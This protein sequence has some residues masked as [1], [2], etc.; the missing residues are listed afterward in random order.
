MFFKRLLLPPKLLWIGIGIFFLCIIP[1]RLNAQL[2]ADFTVDNQTG[3]LAVVSSFTDLS[4]GNPNSWSWTFFYNGVAVD[5]RLTQNPGKI[6]TQ[7]GC[8][9]VQLVV[10]DAAGNRDTLRRNCY[11]EVFENPGMDFQVD[12][13]RAC[14]P[15]TFSFTN[16]TVANADSLQSCTWVFINQSTLSSVSSNANDPV[17]SLPDTGVYDVQL[18]CTNSNGCVNTIRRNGFLR[19]LPT[20][21][22]N[23]TVSDT[24]ACFLPHA[25]TLN[26]ASQDNGAGGLSYAWSIPGG[27]PATATGLTPPPISFNSTNPF[28]AQ[29][30][31]TSAQGCSDSVS[32]TAAVV[33]RSFNGGVTISDTTPCV[34][35][36]VSFQD[37]TPGILSRRWQFGDGTPLLTGP[38]PLVSHTYTSTGTY[39]FSLISTNGFGCE[40]TMVRRIRVLPR[41]GVN[42][43]V[44]PALSCDI[45]TSFAFSD[46][47][48]GGATSWSWDFGDGNTSTLQNPSHT[49]GSAGFYTV[50]LTVTDTSGCDSTFCI[51]SAVSLVTPQAQFIASTD[52]GCA[53]YVSQLTDNSI[54]ND[55]IISWS[56]TFDDGSGTNVTPGT[57][58]LENPNVT[59]LNP[60]TYNVTLVIQTNSGCSDSVTVVNYLRAGPVP[61]VDFTADKDT[62]CI[63]ETVNF[64]SSFTNPAYNYFWDF[65]YPSTASQGNPTMPW[66]YTDT[67]CFDVSLEIEINGCRDSIVKRSM[68]CVDPPLADFT[69]NPSLICLTPTNVV[70][71]NLSQGQVTQHNWYFNNALISTSPNPPPIPVPPSFPSG[72]YDLKLVV[73]NSLTGCTDSLT[74]SVIVGNVTADFSL[75]DKTLCVGDTL[76]VF[77]NS[78]NSTARTLLF[79]DGNLVAGP[80]QPVNTHV[81][82]DTGFFTVR[83]IVQDNRSGCRDTLDKVDSIR[84]DAAFANFSGVGLE[85]C[86]GLVSQFSDSSFASRGS[87]IISWLWDFGDTTNNTATTPNASNAYNGRGFYTVSLAVEAANGCRD[88][89]A[90]RNFVDISQPLLDFTPDPDTTCPGNPVTFLNQ[91]QGL[92]VQYQWIFGTAPGDTST[93]Q[94]PIR[95]YTSLGSKGVILSG[96][97]R[98][99]CT[100]TLVRPHAVFVEDITANFIADRTTGTCPPFSVQFTDLSTGRVDSV[101]WDFGDG[102]RSTQRDPQHI[103]SAPGCFDVTLI[104]FHRDGCSDTL[105]RPCYIDIAGPTA[106]LFFSPSMACLGDTVNFGVAID[107]AA[108]VFLDL[109]DGLVSTTFPQNRTDTVFFQHVYSDTGYFNPVV[110]VQ[111]ARLC[112]RTIPADSSIRILQLPQPQMTPSAFSGCAPFSVNLIDNSAP[113]D[114]NLLGWTWGIST[115]DT[116]VARDTAYTFQNVGI[117][118]VT[119]RVEDAFGCVNDI[120][121]AFEAQSSPV[122]DFVA[123]DSFTCAP[124]SIDF[125]DL[126]SNTLVVDWIWSFG[127]GDSARGVQNP[128]LTYP[129][130]GSYDVSLIVFD[131]NNCSDTLTKS[132]YIRLRHPE[133]YWYADQLSACAPDDITFYADSAQVR[134]DT[135]LQRYTWQLSLPGGQTGTATGLVGSSTDSLNQLYTAPGSYGVTLIVE[136]VFGC[137][138]TLTDSVQL[139]VPPVADFGIADPTGCAPHTTQ[140]WDQSQVGDAPLQG[141]VYD[142]STGDTAFTDSPFYAFQN[143]GVYTVRQL[144]VDANGCVDTSSQQVEIFDSPLP[145]FAASD[146]FNCSPIDIS[147]TDLSSNTT[148]AD[149]R[150]DFGDGNQLSGVQNPTHRYTADGLFDVKLVVTDDQGCVDSLIKSQYIHLRRPTAYIYSNDPS[151]CNPVTLTFFADSSRLLSDTTLTAYTWMIET[152]QGLQAPVTTTVDTFDQVYPVFGLY[153]VVLVVEDVFG[154]TDTMRREDYVEIEETTVPNPISLDVVS[155]LG[156][157]EIE[158]EWEQ[159]PGPARNFNQYYVLRQNPTGGAYLPVDSLPN[160]NTT[161]YVD[162]DPDLDTELRPYRYKIQVQNSC[163]Q[164]SD[165]DQTVAHRTVWLR[166]S[167]EIDAIRLDWS[168]YEGWDP[169]LYQVYGARD[170]NP[171]SLSLIATVPGDRFTFTDTATFCSDVKSYR[172]IAVEGQ[173]ANLRSLSNLDSVAPIHLPPEQPVNISY[174]SVRAD[175]VIDLAWE[176]Y[177]GY[178]PQSYHLEKSSDGTSWALLDTFDL[179]TLQTTDPDVKVDEE[180]YAYRIRAFDQCG[181][182]SPRGYLGVSILLQVELNGKFPELSWTHYREWPLGVLAYEIEVLNESTGLWETVSGVSGNRTRFIDDLTDLNQGL[183][184]YRIRALEARGGENEATSNVACIAFNPRVFAPNAFSPNGDDINDRFIVQGATLRQGQISIFNRWGQMIYSSGDLSEGWDG[185]YEGVAVPEGVYVYV[186]EGQGENGLPISLRGS[187][188]LIR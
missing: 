52:R 113:G 4:N 3:C 35:S 24:I 169:A 109:D 130:D 165:L 7:P 8:H 58:T 53:P 183:Y 180:T 39:T 139:F 102:T 157:R 69:V 60:G 63:G 101:L 20:P 99:G 32:R 156:K 89:L 62:V 182:F 114:T 85:G 15:G 74:Q 187:I 45:N 47:S 41:P 33:L 170:Y 163:L 138:D 116:L 28:T 105:F 12:T 66:A 136:D 40:D 152:D 115:G 90:R 188:T 93:L 166:A 71:T 179:N 9:D 29:L 26:D 86:P 108:S 54:T 80:A 143:P 30:K 37:N 181:D 77:D 123:S 119:L 51:P 61:N 59:V 133:A 34:N 167:P 2:T 147:F 117:Y 176:P 127:N 13:N 65:S 153:D 67:G 88:T 173:G 92:A 50:C 178:L 95:T 161:R 121:Q 122:A 140:F 43:S 134:S 104:A 76:R 23:F 159:F 177:T 96:I 18:R 118:N 120:T 36:P 72:V 70:I 151:G 164:N 154:C 107:S 46:L 106:E 48:T 97:D 100:D 131:G 11:I 149:W 142:F 162:S 57:S 145:D 175:S 111:D 79:G 17:I 144:V 81:Y 49:Y 68:V 126:S 124:V 160:L 186:I 125:T 94:N 38:P 5:T 128:R 98:R 158:M 174:A 168:A 78:I 75:S 148:A 185:T 10:T 87:P 184:C 44:T 22:A 1:Q 146:T 55:S 27:T 135:T 64:T 103:Y 171:G 25:V 83:M 137:A 84:V 73:N 141:W 6:F 155:V 172:V 91:S 31:V 112:Q 56:W 129:Q 110:L 150:W 16:L 14:S 132:Q 82:Q 21:T 19:V 42:F